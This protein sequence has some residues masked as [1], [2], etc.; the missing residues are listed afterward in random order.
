M[1]Q[2][3]R[4]RVQGARC[5]E[6]YQFKKRLSNTRR[7]RRASAGAGGTPAMRERIYPSKF[8]SAELVAGC[9]SVLCGLL[10]LK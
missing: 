1:V 6:F 10:I 4:F 8:D 7:T 3:T 5:I 9:G 2:G